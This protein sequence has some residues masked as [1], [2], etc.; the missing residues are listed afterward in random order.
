MLYI[1]FVIWKGSLFSWGSGKGVLLEGW[2]EIF[3]WNDCIFKRDDEVYR[4]YLVIEN[5]F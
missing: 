4:I 5:D 2:F 3:I 1:K